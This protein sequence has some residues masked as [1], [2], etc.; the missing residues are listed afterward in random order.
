M[1]SPSMGFNRQESEPP[2]SSHPRRHRKGEKSYLHIVRS[3]KVRLEQL[4]LSKTY[5]KKETINSRLID[6]QGCKGF[7]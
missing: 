6:I 2:T 3:N 1:A 7:N 5:S 4:I